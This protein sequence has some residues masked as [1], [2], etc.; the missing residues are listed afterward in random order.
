MKGSAHFA[1]SRWPRAFGDEDVSYR[2]NWRIHMHRLPRAINAQKV[3]MILYTLVL[4]FSVSGNVFASGIV[5]R[6]LNAPIAS[7]GSVGNDGAS[8]TV[9][10]DLFTGAIS[11]SVPINLPKGMNELLPGI[12]LRYNSMDAEDGSMGPGW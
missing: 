2:L 6:A 3:I 1:N 11:H 12:T 9:L 10:P 5:K 7:D 4:V 8:A